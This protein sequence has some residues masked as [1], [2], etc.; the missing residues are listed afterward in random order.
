ML[1]RIFPKQFDNIYRGHWLG[2]WLFAA[3]VL[4]KALQGLNSIVMTRQ[5]MTTADGIPLDSFNAAAAQAATGMFTLLGMYLL[6]LP[7]L[8]LVA[9]VRYR[10]MIPFLYLM[11]LA[12]QVSSRL[13]V[14]WHPVIASAELP[15]GFFV[16]LGIL[17]I[18]LLGFVL[19]LQNRESPN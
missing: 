14:L 6:V 15:V 9:L 17:A 2:L 19:S 11:L 7:L 3:V 5:V 8:S 12:V 4:V 16:N 18:T 1:S 13:L 10:S